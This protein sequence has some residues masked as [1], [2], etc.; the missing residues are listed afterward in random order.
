MNVFSLRMQRSPSSSTYTIVE[1]FPAAPVDSTA[2]M[3]ASKVASG[4]Q[5][6][7]APVSTI[8]LTRTVLAESLPWLSFEPSSMQNSDDP[9]D[10]SSA[11][12]LVGPLQ[13]S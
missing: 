13:P 10:L 12:I 11:L 7:N 4:I 2:S 9:C 6:R 1:F 5:I 8:T 3:T